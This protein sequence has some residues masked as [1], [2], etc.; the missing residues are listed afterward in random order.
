MKRSIIAF[1]SIALAFAAL[2]S[3]S[4]RP[5]FAQAQKIPP[6]ENRLLRLSEIMGSLHFL[7]LLC[8]ASEGAIWHDKMNEILDVEAKTQLRK[9]K[10][11]ERFNAGFGSFQATY[12]KCTPSAETAMAR[13][14]TEAQVIVRNLTTDFSG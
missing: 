10:L 7:T 8:R 14:I 13:Y 1:L 5:A 12:R 4:V 11:T 3:T 2:T 6:Y 9:A